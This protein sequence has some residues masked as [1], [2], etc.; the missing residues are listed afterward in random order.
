M[1]EERGREGSFRIH[2]RRPLRRIKYGR[3]QD[4]NATSF[5]PQAEAGLGTEMW[6]WRISL[7]IGKTVLKL[8]AL[9]RCLITRERTLHNEIE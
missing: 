9:F 5:V 8:A 3:R 4:G 1:E 2:L 6:V 7:N